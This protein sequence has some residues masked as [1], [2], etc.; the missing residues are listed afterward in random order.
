[1]PPPESR[2][3]TARY[4]GKVFG[5]DAEVYASFFRGRLFDVSIRF[6]RASYDDFFILQGAIEDEYA[7]REPTMGASAT[8]EQSPITGGGNETGIT[9][10]MTEGK[11]VLLAYTNLTRKDEALREWRRAT[12]KRREEIKKQL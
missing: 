7:V 5:M 2:N 10:A 11:S 1:M 12:E 3:L 9:V 4:S 6:P 8:P